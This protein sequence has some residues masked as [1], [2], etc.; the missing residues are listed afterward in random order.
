MRWCFLQQC[1]L[2]VSGMQIL[3]KLY[4]CQAHS[5]NMFAWNLNLALPAARLIW[6]AQIKPSYTQGRFLTATETSAHLKIDAKIIRLS[7]TRGKTKQPR[8]MFSFAYIGILRNMNHQKC[9]TLPY[10]RVLILRGAIK[11]ASSWETLVGSKDVSLRCL[12]HRERR[13]KRLLWSLSG[14][15]TSPQ[16]NGSH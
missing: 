7:S 16:Q 12:G 5:L 9:H 14:R 11:S 4:H 13:V 8:H 6:R 1:L 15:R 2:V 3:T 10:Q